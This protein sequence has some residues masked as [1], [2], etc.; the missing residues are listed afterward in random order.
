VYKT[1]SEK[2]NDIG[3]TG[4][5]STRGTAS[6]GL[7]APPNAVQAEQYFNRVRHQYDE[8]RAQYAQVEVHLQHLKLQL[9]DTLPNNRFQVLR[10]EVERVGARHQEL[11]Q[12]V[13]RYKMLARVAALD[14]FGATFYEV[15]K[16]KM[17][18]VLFKALSYETE[19]MLE[20]DLL[21][22]IPQSRGEATNAGFFLWSIVTGKPT[23]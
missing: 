6:G 20:R 1:S 5:A 7:V 17:D 10:G 21:A 2:L 22:G 16:R 3:R 9:R 11:Q 8:L 4:S 14:A 12:E 23:A 19:M 13:S 18:P 15:A